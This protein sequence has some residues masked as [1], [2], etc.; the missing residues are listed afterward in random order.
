MPSKSTP[1]KKVGR[2]SLFKPGST[3]SFTLM[4]PKG[5]VKKLRTLAKKQDVSMSHLVRTAVEKLIR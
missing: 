1:T 2:P 3:S 4:I 5:Y